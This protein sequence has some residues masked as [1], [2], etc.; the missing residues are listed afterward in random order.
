VLLPIVSAAEIEHQ[1]VVTGRQLT[2]R[3]MEHPGLALVVETD[4]G[5][6]SV[7]P[8]STGR[9]ST[10]AQNAA[11]T[12]AS[13]QSKEYIPTCR[14]ESDDTWPPPRSWKPSLG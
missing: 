6:R 7:A 1:A 11:R 13:R 10:A 14:F 12:A 4:R 5:E 2:G 3:L 8:S 9:C